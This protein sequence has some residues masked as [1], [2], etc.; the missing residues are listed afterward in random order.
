MLLASSDVRSGMPVNILQCTGWPPEQR[1][2]QPQISQ[3][4]WWR[5]TVL[6]PTTPNGQEMPGTEEHVKRH[7]LQIG[8]ILQDKQLPFFSKYTRDG[9]KKRSKRFLQMKGF[10]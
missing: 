9:E 6:D 8:N 3:A 1:L 5:D 7:C 10:P 4:S 2:I